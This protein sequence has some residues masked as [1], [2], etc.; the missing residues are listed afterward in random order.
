MKVVGWDGRVRAESPVATEAMLK[1][2]RALAATWSW[3]ESLI[4]LFLSSSIESDD[5]FRLCALSKRGD[6]ARGTMGLRRGRLSSR[7]G[8]QAAPSRL[9]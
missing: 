3:I 5:H 2:S 7:V 9:L 4:L 6:E 8:S 1:D